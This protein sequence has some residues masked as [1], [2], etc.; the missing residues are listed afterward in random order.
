VDDKTIKVTFCG[1]KEVLVE[2]NILGKLT[3]SLEVLLT[4]ATDASANTHY[5]FYC[6]GYGAFDRLASKAIDA[7]RSKYPT[8]QVEKIFV[9]PYITPAYQ[10][11]NA[12][13]KKFYD[14]IVYPPLESVPLRFA[15]SR[16][17][18]WMVD[19]S[20]I[21]YAYVTHSWG[22]AAKTLEYAKRKNKKIV[23]ITD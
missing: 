19:N 7:V 5:I 1:H 13:M 11:K 18:E 21:V 23:Y 14:E 3:D 2:S 6:G 8:V 4:A 20:D 12:Y 10:E 22:G 15:I 16:R 9:T 17:N